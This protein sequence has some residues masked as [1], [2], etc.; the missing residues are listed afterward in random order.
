MTQKVCMMT[1]ASRGL[2]AELAKA[3][4]AAG[5]KVIATGRETRGLN[6]P[7]N[8]EEA[9]LCLEMDVT[10]NAQVQSASARVLADSAVLTCSLTTPASGYLGLGAIVAV[11]AGCLLPLIASSDQGADDCQNIQRPQHNTGCRR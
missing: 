7:G 3:A 10:N 11:Y 2:G 8:Q 6:C 1:G 9:W 5:D 4:V